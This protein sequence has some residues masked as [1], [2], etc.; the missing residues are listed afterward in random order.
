MVSF[1]ILI[2]VIIVKFKEGG[3]FTLLITVSF[4][5]IAWLIRREYD[6]LRGLLRGLD[7][8]GLH[9]ITEIQRLTAKGK[10]LP[11]PVKGGR[12]A[13]ILV[14]GFHG[15]GLHTLFAAIR[16]FPGY[17]KRFV[18]VS[19][20]LVDAGHY[21]GVKEI[22]RH[23]GSLSEELDHYV[24]YMQLQG[25]QS[26]K[27][28]LL[29]TDLIDGVDKLIRLTIK[30]YPESMVFAGRLLFENENFLTRLLHTTDAYA[31]QKRLYEIG[32]PVCVLPTRSEAGL[33]KS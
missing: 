11:A 21:K 13:I 26:E 16:H 18:F 29:D 14:S 7:D 30:D 23:E 24:Q 10:A 31:I 32:V 12:T 8:V 19:V 27:K 15:V 2:S 4:A 33:K 17:F 3:Y 9:V 28:F 22:E 5:L 1:F 6:R 20:G 25:F